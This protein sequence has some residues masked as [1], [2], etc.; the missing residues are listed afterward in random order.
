MLSFWST[1]APLPTG[2][3]FLGTAAGSDGRI[4]AIGGSTN[5]AVPGAVATVESYT[6]GT[7]T[8]LPATSMHTARIGPAAATGPDGLIYA[9]GGSTADGAGGDN[10]TGVAV[11]IVEAYDSA[12]NQWSPVTPLSSPQGSPGAATGPDGR[13]YA[14]SGQHPLNQFGDLLA[15][16]PVSTGV[17]SYSPGPAGTPGLWQKEPSPSF[18][19]RR[20]TE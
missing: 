18:A 5:N 10:T 16:A 9:I 8:W 17:Q 11:P 13:I 20:I 14:I 7:D 15:G 19:S 2:R 4:Y 1:V 12:T 6:T 3:G